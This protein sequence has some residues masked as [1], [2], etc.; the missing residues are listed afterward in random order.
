[1]QIR[2]TKYEGVTPGPWV[3]CDC[4]K[5]SLI[6]SIPMDGTVLRGIGRDEEDTHFP[7]GNLAD[8]RLAADAPELLAR[9][10][11]LA[12]AAEAVA[13]SSS[14]ED[15]MAAFRTLSMEVQAWSR[16]VGVSPTNGVLH[17]DSIQSALKRELNKLSK[18]ERHRLADLVDK[19]RPGLKAEKKKKRAFRREPA[20]PP[21]DPQPKE[22]VTRM[23]LILSILGDAPRKG[24]RV[25]EI[26]HE[27]STRSP[28]W[29]RSSTSKLVSMA[30]HHDRH[31]K[32]PRTR[33]V[34]GGRRGYPAHYALVK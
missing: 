7:F 11:A 4:G 20:P 13:K 16:L 23:G 2:K 8:G 15:R 9:G 34:S 29:G 31:T 27:I 22:G 17:R 10:E 5:C 26:I 18:P 24:L 32:N 3:M 28:E 19:Q 30:L 25:S 33:M 14:E 1:M 6:W 21:S 12:Q